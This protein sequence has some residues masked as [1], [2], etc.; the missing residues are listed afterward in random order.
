MRKYLGG[1]AIALIMANP[2]YATE[3]WILQFR[4]NNGNDHLSCHYDKDD[5]PAKSYRFYKKNDN[6]VTLEDHDD[7]VTIRIQSDQ[8]I[9]SLYYFRGE[10]ACLAGIKRLNDRK[11]EENTTLEQYDNTPSTSSQQTENVLPGKRFDSNIIKKSN[12]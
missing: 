6:E 9:V 2:A 1:A 11:N 10:E 12:R 4:D 5:S 7:E 8:N 3:W